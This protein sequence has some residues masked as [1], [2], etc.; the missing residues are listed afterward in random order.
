MEKIQIKVE[1]RHIDA[2]TPGDKCNCPIGLALK[3]SGMN[4]IE[5]YYESIW[6]DSRVVRTPRIARKFAIDFDLSLPVEP[7]EFELTTA[8]W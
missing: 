2:G 8:Y 5:V 3:D 4:D 1:Q 7:F 6:V